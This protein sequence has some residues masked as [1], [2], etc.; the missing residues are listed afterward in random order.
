VAERFYIKELANGMTLL[1]QQMEHVASAAM[2]LLVPAGAAHD[3]DGAAGA[4]AVCAEWCFR[5][6]G[7]RDSRQLNRALDALGCQHS[8]SVLSEQVQFT[9]AQLGRNLG[10]VLGIYADI[11]R[12]P[13]LADETFEPCRQ[14]TIQDLQSLEDEPA[15][16]C[17]VILREKFYPY[18]LGRCIYGR[19]ESLEALQPDAARAQVRRGLTPAG[20]ILGVA[21]R[22]DWDQLCSVAEELFGDWSSGPAPPI[23]RRAAD[24]GVTYIQKQSSQAHIALAHRSVTPGD[25]HYYAA[26]VAESVLSGGMSSR[27]F[28][29]VREKRGLAYHASTRYH[30]LKDCA[31]M[32]TYAGTPPE[33]AQETLEVTIRELRRLAEGVEEAE[34]ARSRTQ[35]KSTLIMQGESTVARAGALVADWHHLRRLRSL[36]ELADAIDGVTAGEVM[37][38]LE[39]YPA[40]DFTALVIGP[41]PLD[42]ERAGG[43]R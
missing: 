32:F 11:L 36:Q 38:Y 4:A 10:Q 18:P 5:G 27:L 14:L 28:T 3:P 20:A 8:Q 19:A 35:L 25:S 42:I 26:R 13:R 33:H 30:T 2:S 31:G 22:I 16:K 15:R 39:R 23:D 17:S 6:A 24:G 7:E 43:T 12:R 1:G 29:E 34:L 21:G 41:E 40:R 9:A 37:E